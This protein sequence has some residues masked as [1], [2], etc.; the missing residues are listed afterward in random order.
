MVCIQTLQLPLAEQPQRRVAHADPVQPLAG[1]HR[2]DQGRTHAI[3]FG[4]FGNGGGQCGIGLVE[5]GAEPI[6]NGAGRLRIR[7]D[8]GLAQKAAGRCAAHVTAHAI[9][10]Q[11][12]GVLA[13]V[14]AE[15]AAV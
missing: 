2:R 3:E 12:H 1:N 7:L 11:Q 13:A 8:K 15:V 14:Q 9:G 4:V 5:A 10:D 6:D